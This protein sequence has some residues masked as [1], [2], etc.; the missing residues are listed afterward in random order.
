MIIRPATTS[1]IPSITEIYARSVDQEFVSFELEPPDDVEMLKRMNG[2]KTKNYPYLVAEVE[3]Q[4]AGY[5]YASAHRPRPAYSKTVESTVYVAPQ[6]WRQGIASSLLTALVETC[7]K[8]KFREMI[9][10]AACEPHAELSDIPSIQL[11]LS[12]GFVDSGRLKS[13]GHKHGKWLDIVL[14]QRS[15]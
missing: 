1:D 5:A 8:Q 15:L 7:R 12:N 6:F 3:N 2:L 4:V 9:A 11:H 13:V 10:I 14:M